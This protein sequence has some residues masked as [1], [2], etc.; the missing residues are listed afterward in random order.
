MFA[1]AAVAVLSKLPIPHP[2]P[3]PPG[4][5]RCSPSTN[6]L[7]I[8]FDGGS[9]D[10]HTLYE[11][12]VGLADHPTFVSV[13]STTPA[14]TIEDLWPNTTYSLLL[15]KRELESLEPVTTAQRS[16]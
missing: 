3:T 7:A 1:V 2:H 5:A 4:A 12:Q 13:T 15:R 16:C 8:A 6:S 14:A 10:S 11:V 9:H